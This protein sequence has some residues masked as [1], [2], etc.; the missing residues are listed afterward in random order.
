MGG[1]WGIHRVCLGLRVPWDAF[2][3]GN[4]GGST[5]GQRLPWLRCEVAQIRT[6]GCST[7]PEN[8]KDGFTPCSLRAS[9]HL[10]GR[11]PREV[12]PAHFTNGDR[13]SESHIWNT[14]QLGCKPRR[15]SP[16]SPH[17]EPQHS[18]ARFESCQPLTRCCIHSPPR[19]WQLTETIEHGACVWVCVCVWVCR[20]GK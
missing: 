8:W 5:P 19:L 6:R 18:E 10:R 13:G 9:P 7:G 17:S 2:Q 20:W 1:Q 11:E 12:L 4:E 15:A 16:R 3:F 14:A